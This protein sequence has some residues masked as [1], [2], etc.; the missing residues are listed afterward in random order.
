[1]LAKE[2]L[3]VGRAVQSA[4]M[5][6]AIPF[7]PGWD[8]WMYSRPAREVGGDMVD[9]IPIDEKRRAFVLA[10]IAGKGLGAALFMTRLQAVLHALIP[11]YSQP[12]GLLEKLNTLFHR[13]HTPNRFA[14]LFYLE[15]KPDTAELV[16]VNA[17]HLPPLVIQNRRLKELEKG[18]PALGLMDKTKYIEKTIH[19]KKEDILLVYSDGLSEAMSENREFFGE[20]RI[21][22]IVEKAADQSAQDIGK[23][24]IRAIK[25]FTKDSPLSDDLSLLIIKNC[26][27]GHSL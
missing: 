12:A 7:I 11:D 6:G 14:S 17:G 24:L 18:Q 2:E 1:M 23:Q 5:P 15:I 26:G 25:N 20:K 27:S 3:E 22:T 8:I 9:Y 4:L 13:D 16:Y 10:D 21:K 19:I